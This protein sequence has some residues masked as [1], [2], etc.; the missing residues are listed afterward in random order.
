MARKPVS[1][2]TLLAIAG[3]IADGNLQA[4]VPG[5]PVAQSVARG[6]ILQPGGP[7]TGRLQVAAP[8]G[9]PDCLR[10]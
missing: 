8:Q 5:L 3:A 6:E 4:L 9:D 1:K 2:T 7:V 10:Q